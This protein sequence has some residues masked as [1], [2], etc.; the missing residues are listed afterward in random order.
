MAKPQLRNSIKRA[1]VK[2]AKLAL[3]NGQNLVCEIGQRRSYADDHVAIGGPKKIV[4]NR[5]S[6]KFL[7]VTR[8]S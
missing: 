1:M 2:A 7:I 3:Q 4:K 5:F 6:I 8:L